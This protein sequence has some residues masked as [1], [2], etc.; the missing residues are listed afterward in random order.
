[1]ARGNKFTYFTKADINCPVCG[2]KFRREELLTGRGRLIA[3]DLTDELR[4]IYVPSAKFGEVYPLNYTMV[5]CPDCYYT[6]FAADFQRLPNEAQKNLKEGKAKRSELIRNLF[7]DIDFRNPRTLKEG[8]ATYLLG[9]LTYDVMPTN[10]SPT[11][12][13]GICSLRAAWLL[14]DLH[15]KYPEE[16]WEYLAQLFYRKACFFYTHA[17]EVES[18]DKENI[19]EVAHLGPDLDKNYGYDG[20]LYIS[21]LLEY[22]YGASGDRVVRQKTLETAKRTVSQVFGMGKATKNK[23]TVLLEWAKD[24]FTR[25]GEELDGEPEPD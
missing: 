5:T 22:R 1:M 11:I 8:T 21:A 3:G 13:Q 4:R 16:N 25:M 12:K 20:V 9:I 14:K 23:P 6:A 18:E 17:V 10:F 7:R 15:G 24:L 2:A 19:A